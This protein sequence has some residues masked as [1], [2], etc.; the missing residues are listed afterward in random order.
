MCTAI[1]YKTAN[2]YFGRNLDLEYSYNET[3]T[4]TPRKYSLPFC[5]MPSINSHYAMI[6]M[7]YVQDGYPLY[8]DA[9]NEKGLSMA[10]LSFPDYA[11]YNEKQNHADNIAPFEFIPWV[12]SQCK[13][14]E[15]AKMLLSSVSITNE[16]FSEALQP[17]PLHWMISDSES[18]IV[19]ES[20]AK[21]L[22]VL[23]N[24]VGVLTNSPTF[25]YHMA[26]LNNYM[27][28]SNKPV[29]NRFAPELPLHEFSRGMGGAGLPGDY[30]SASRFVKAAF[31]LHNSVGGDTEEENISQFFHI[32]SSVAHP[33]GSVDLG[34]GK[35]EI[36]VY[37]SCC[38]TNKGIYYYTTY[39]NSSINA[40][41]MHREDLDSAELISYPL[42]SRKIHFQ[43]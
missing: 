40:V 33:K 16:A 41:D 15:D 6:G 30:S 26:N 43:N 37:S 32:L 31:V 10:G 27:G 8:Y 28:I 42:L 5:E 17:T 34:D 35:Y 1:S 38:N 39:N 24:P 14:I 4:I 25:D 12:L 23:D 13:S 36:T 18:S 19:V 7:A 21:G 20:T 11:K 2:H 9:T 3:V 29:Q 22:A